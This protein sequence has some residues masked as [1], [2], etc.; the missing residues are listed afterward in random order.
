MEGYQ[1]IIVI[2]M[3]RLGMKDARDDEDV[4]VFLWQEGIGR[5][6]MQSTIPA[7]HLSLS[8]ARRVSQSTAHTCEG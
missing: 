5:I 4:C 6:G 1:Q 7:C 3:G 8:M 2:N